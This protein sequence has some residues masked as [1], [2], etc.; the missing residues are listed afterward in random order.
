MGISGDLFV[1]IVIFKSCLDQVKLIRC[2]FKEMDEIN[3]KSA[4]SQL[5][6]VCPTML[7]SKVILP[8]LTL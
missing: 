2:V 3:V 4:A 5:S 7:K 6:E 1:V 8:S